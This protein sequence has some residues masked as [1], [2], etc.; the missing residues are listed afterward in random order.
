MKRS[1]EGSIY[2]TK[3][4]SRWFARLRYTDKSGTQR[5]K[6]RT[7]IS[8]A[9]AKAEI[10][11]LK[12]EV[13]DDARERK[14]YRE[15]DAFFRKQ[16]VHAAKFVGGKLVSGFRQDTATVER[17]LDRALEHFADTPIDA[18]TYA[19]VRE[20][21]RRIE[22]L[23]T[24]SGA[25]SVSDTNHHLK[26][27]RRL[28]NIAVEQSWLSVNPFEKGGSLIVESFEVERT[29]ILT[30]DEETKML[31]ACDKWR[32]HLKPIIILAIETA[33]RRGE[34]QSLLWSNI[35]LTG[36]LIRIAASNTKTLKTRLVPISQRLKE[37]L[38]QLRQHQLRPNSRVFQSGD[39]K[40][41]FAGACSDAEITDLHFHDLRHTAITRMLEKG[42]SPPLVMK[43][44]GHTQQRTF[45]RYVN[46]T[47][48][49][50]MEIALKLDRAAA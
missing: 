35:D 14:T 41:A 45:M 18:I 9:K 44:S 34:I 2:K 24:K 20:Y 36:R 19:D 12:A 42:I 5:E 28:F 39:F 37:T 1:F 15:L 29:R 50:I 46:Q 33:M 4:G 25:R 40:K 23:P 43:I 48:Q 22:N 32:Q 7:C 16:Y 17:Y 38:A 27:V 11:N 3:D 8:H 30:A 47:E 26:R 13:A 31:A 21:K 6:K 10:K 49:S